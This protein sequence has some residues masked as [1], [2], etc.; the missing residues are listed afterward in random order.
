MEMNEDD[1]GRIIIG[2][3]IDLHRELGPGLLETVYETILAKRL[4]DRGLRVH[5]QK[6][7]PIEY[8]GVQF[9]A[10]FRVDLIVEDK[11]I[12]EV[13]SVEH[14]NKVHHKQV[15]TYLRLTGKKLG[16]LLNFGRPVMRSGISRIINGT[17]ESSPGAPDDREND[18]SFR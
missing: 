5:R 13:K 17:I 12:I 11:V 9:K 10:G 6:P 14:L 8:D 18:S 7:V 2:C 4:G 1:I 16:Y 3:A 15:L